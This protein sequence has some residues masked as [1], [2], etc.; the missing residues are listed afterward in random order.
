MD[1]E[2]LH[3]LALNS[4]PYMHPATYHALL[5]RFG[6]AAEVFRARREDLTALR[7]V[8]PAMADLIKSSAPEKLAEAEISLAEKLGAGILFL[9]GPDY[10]EPLKKIHAPPPVL[11]VMGRWRKEDEFS[12]A[13]VGTREPTPYGRNTAERLSEGLARAGLTVVSG[14]ARGIDG[15]AHRAALK[16]GGRTVAALGCGLNINYPAN[17]GDMKKRIAEN[18]AVISQFGLTMEPSLVSFPIRN[19]VVAGLT[20]GTIVVEAPV[21]S[22]ALITAYAALDCGKEVFAVP[23]QV[24]SKKSEGANRLIQKGYARLCMSAQ[25]VIDDLPDPARK[26]IKA[27]QMELGLE[28]NAAAEA[29]LEGEEAAIAKILED[30]ERHIDQVAAMCGLPLGKVSAILL[31]LEIKGLVKQASGKMFMRS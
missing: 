9:D 23:G 25:D 6:A 19:R 1:R 5:A 17:H 31:S 28:E 3:A 2:K 18:G 15:T 20:L 10:P 7:E 22:G 27:R 26:W 12:V 30:G 14:F 29:A 8:S 24:N 11:Y 13:V 4:L 21:E 16:A